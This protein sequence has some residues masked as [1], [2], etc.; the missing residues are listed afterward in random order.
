MSEVRATER[1]TAEGTSSEL[2]P[3]VFKTAEQHLCDAIVLHVFALSFEACVSDC[4]ASVGLS[5]RF[6]EQSRC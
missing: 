5:A 6:S 3:A 1:Y 4:V 2:S